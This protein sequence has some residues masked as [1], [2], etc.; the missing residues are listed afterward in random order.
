[1]TAASQY[2]IM[3][4]PENISHISSLMSLFTCKASIVVRQT[5][6]K[7]NSH[8]TFIAGAELGITLALGAIASM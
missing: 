1:M 7:A 5:K 6:E 2:I 4:V 8:N 3:L